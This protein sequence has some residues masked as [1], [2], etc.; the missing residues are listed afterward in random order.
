ML[1]VMRKHSRSFLIYVFFGII[2]AVF[3]INFGPQ[4]AGC[5]T[6]GTSYA[7]TVTGQRISIADFEYAQSV[8]GLRQ[9]Q[10]SEQQLVQLRKMVMDRLIARELLAK[11]AL[12]M[13]Y[14][15]PIKEIR[16][17][18]FSG[19]YLALGQPRPLIRGED[20]AFD[21]SRFSRYVRYYWGLNVK[22]FQDQQRRELLADKMRK[23]LE[24]VVRVSEDEVKTD[25]L[26]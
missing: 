3:V 13:G 8:L 2:I 6:S 25:I 24:T 21:Y 19:R 12:D 4:S 15:I 18:I 9:R 1:D 5:V 7:G 23:Y 26:Q 14:K 11:R 22:R 16:D 17:M 10:G 20:G